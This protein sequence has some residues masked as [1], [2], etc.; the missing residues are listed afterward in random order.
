MKFYMTN[1]LKCH[2]FLRHDIINHINNIVNDIIE[3][4]CNNTGYG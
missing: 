4:F 3:Q 2:A 1:I